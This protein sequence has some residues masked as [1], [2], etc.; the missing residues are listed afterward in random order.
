MVM[1]FPQATLTIGTGQTIDVYDGVHLTSLLTGLDALQDQN[2]VVL[3]RGHSDFIKATR[4]G[5]LWSVIAK[6]DK[7]WMA[8][9]FTAALTSDYSERCARDS[10]THK[11]LRE[12]LSKWLRSPSP[13]QAISTEQVRTLFAEYLSGKKF[14]IP[15]SGA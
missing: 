4:Q 1:Q 12:R 5:E 8:Q 11:S 6:R 3:E 9:S 7:M 2:D 10:R 13:E 14:T 15:I